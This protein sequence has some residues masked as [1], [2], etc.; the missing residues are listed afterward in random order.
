MSQLTDLKDIKI[1]ERH[2]EAKVGPDYQR[3]IDA[4]G[5]WWHRV[6][7]HPDFPRRC[8]LCGESVPRGWAPEAGAVTALDFI[9]DNHFLGRE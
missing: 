6:V 9:C 8:H 5:A 1:I 4:N 7:G 3:A 2:P